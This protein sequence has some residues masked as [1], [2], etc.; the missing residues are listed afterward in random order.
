M[1]TTVCQCRNCGRPTIAKRN[2]RLH[3]SGACR[4]AYSR[5]QLFQHFQVIRVKPEY[6]TSQNTPYT[7]TQGIFPCVKEKE[8]MP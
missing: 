6:L 7:Y 4:A 2:T 8:S 1:T 5:K 3:C